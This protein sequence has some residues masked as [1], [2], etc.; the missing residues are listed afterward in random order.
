MNSMILHPLQTP[1]RQNTLAKVALVISGPGNEG[2]ALER[3]IIEPK[4][5]LFPPTSTAAAAAGQPGTS[6]LQTSSSNLDILEFEAQLRAILLK[7]QYID[8]VLP[9]KPPIGSTFQIVVYTAGRGGMAVDAWI[10]EQ[11]KGGSLLSE[12]GLEMKESENGSGIS[13]AEIVPIKSCKIE[14]ALQLQIYLERP[15]PN[16]S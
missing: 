8:A 16:Y 11:G 14:G 9:P 3:F 10:E 12:Q 4:L 2:Q 1:L 5:L 7:L 15:S 6:A 13:G